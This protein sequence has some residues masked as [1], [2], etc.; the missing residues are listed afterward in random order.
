MA[1]QME[2]SQSAERPYGAYRGGSDYSQQQ[3]EA[4]YQQSAQSGG[5]DDNLV[6]AVAQRL[7]Q[8]IN[9]G[10]AGKVGAS[11]RRDKSIPA[12]QR[13]GIAIVSVIALV[14]IAIVLGQLGLGGLIAL[15]I[16]CA[17]IFLINALA[18]GWS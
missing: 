10:A 9:Q 17:V 4:P 3:Y 1:S 7:A 2:G 18:N 13:T 14:P 5:L 15:G 6:E 16:V 12:E 8:R 11:Q